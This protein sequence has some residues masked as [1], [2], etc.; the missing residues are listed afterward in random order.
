MIRG[1][2]VCRECGCILKRIIIS[3]DINSV[4][5]VL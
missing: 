4:K 2:V 5:R 1:S 3:G